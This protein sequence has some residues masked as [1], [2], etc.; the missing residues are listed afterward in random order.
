MKKAKFSSFFCFSIREGE[1]LQLVLRLRGGPLSSAGEHNPAAVLST[2]DDLVAAYDDDDY[3]YAD[4]DSPDAT[5]RHVIFS[6]YCAKETDVT[7]QRAYGFRGV[8]GNNR[9]AGAGS[10]HAR[11]LQV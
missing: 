7:A 2:S 10:S 4:Y 11:H 5:V 1:S 3:Q 9:P 6:A 8:R